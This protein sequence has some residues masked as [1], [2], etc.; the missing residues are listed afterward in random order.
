MIY[1]HD[2]IIKLYPNVRVI[3]G[4]IAYDENE[5]EINYDNNLVMYEA[6]LIDLR[7]KSVIYHTFQGVI[8]RNRV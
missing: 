3:R 2:A 8:L 4:D 6:G 1:K 7:Q 5:N